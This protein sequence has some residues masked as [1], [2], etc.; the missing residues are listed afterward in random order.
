MPKYR[1]FGVAV[2]TAGNERKGDA[3]AVIGDGHTEGF[4]VGRPQQLTALVRVGLAVDWPNGVDDILGGQIEAR[5]DGRVAGFDRG[6]FVG[7]RLELVCASSSEDG[8]RDPA[9]HGEAG[10][11]GVD[12]GVDG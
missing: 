9:A 2:N 12:D 7:S 10:I 6:H 8:T 1:F 5:C 3:A 11:G 4:C